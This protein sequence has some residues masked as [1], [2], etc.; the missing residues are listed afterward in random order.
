MATTEPTVTVDQ[1]A[2][3]PVDELR[4]RQARL[5]VVTVPPGAQAPVHHH[6]GA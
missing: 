3:W 4:G 5:L 1:V 6:D 2:V